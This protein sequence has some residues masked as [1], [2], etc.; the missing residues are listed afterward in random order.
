MSVAKKL[1][2]ASLLFALAFPFANAVAAVDG[3]DTKKLHALF[4]AQWEEQARAFPELSTERGDYRYNDKLS[5][6]SPAARAAYEAKERDW[7]K[8]ARA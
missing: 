6:R 7:L 4:D 8:Q 3:Q 5:D 2:A 1:A